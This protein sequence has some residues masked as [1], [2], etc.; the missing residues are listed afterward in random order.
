MKTNPCIKTLAFFAAL[1]WLGSVQYYAADS[2]QPPATASES[3]KPNTEDL[4]V[5]VYQGQTRKIARIAD[6]NPL[7]VTVMFEGGGGRRIP[8]QE[9]PPQ[10]KTKYPYDADKAD[11][12]EVR[13]AR[14]AAEQAAQ[15]QEVLKG[16]MSRKEQ[17][18]QASIT[19]NH[20]RIARIQEEIA[21]LNR[22][23]RNRPR[24]SSSLRVKK[25]GLIKQ[26]ADLRR[27][28]SSWEDQLKVTRSQ[29]GSLP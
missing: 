15:Q 29:S 2:T 8:L 11:E 19:A 12:Y 18:L 1:L 4:G 13:E 27:Q 9:L 24:K 22:Q 28:I 21:A 14:K 20:V 6:A 23:I 10:L 26:Q 3:S 5:D 16:Q 25:E 17:G 7:F